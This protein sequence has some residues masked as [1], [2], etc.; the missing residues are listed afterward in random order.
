[1]SDPV[2]DP[3]EARLGELLQTLRDDAPQTSHALAVR[4]VAR[5]RWQ[6]RLREAITVVGQ[7]ASAAGDVARVLLGRGRGRA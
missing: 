7:L 4:V 1:M 2:P 6:A 5:V 3:A